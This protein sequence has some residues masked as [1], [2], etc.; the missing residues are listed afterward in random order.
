MG[1][2]TVRTCTASSATTSP[3]AACRKITAL[4][5]ALRKTAKP[6]TRG[7]ARSPAG[8]SPLAQPD[9]RLTSGSS[10]AL[11]H[12]TGS[13]ARPLAPSSLLAAPADVEA[14]V[15]VGAVEAERGELTVLIADRGGAV[16]VHLRVRV[17]HVF[18]PDREGDGLAERNAEFQVDQRLASI[19]RVE[20][21]LRVPRSSPGHSRRHPRPHAD[22]GDG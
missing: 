8:A 3:D 2:I 17:Q 21:G 9:P 10:M 18:T 14:R 15:V 19:G 13:P 1:A 12:Q 4:P 20:P 5:S 7:D 22:R 6:G 16:L 11:K